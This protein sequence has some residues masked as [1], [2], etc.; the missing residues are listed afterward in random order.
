MR[1]ASK[2]HF[3]RETGQL[4][5]VKEKDTDRE[6]DETKIEYCLDTEGLMLVLFQ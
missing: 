2:P 5:D 4:V 1:K 6:D 3:D